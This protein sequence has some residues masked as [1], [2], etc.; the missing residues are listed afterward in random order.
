MTA[1]SEVIVKALAAS[2]P[3]TCFNWSA[4]RL[5]KGYR[6]KLMRFWGA[7]RSFFA[8]L[9][10]GRRPGQTLYT[11]ANSSW[12]MLYDFFIL[13][14]GR[15]LGYRL[16]LHHH[17]YSYIDRYDWRMGLVN[18]V[19]GKRGAHAVHC[20]KMAED[21]RAHYPTSA[22]FLMVP[23][24]I[25]SREPSGERNASVAGY[26][27]DRP[28]VLGFLSNLTLA[29]G[30]P[31][32]LETFEQLANDGADVQLLL[33]GPCLQTEA[34]ELVNSALDKWPQRIAY[35]GP[36][37]GAE[38]AAYYSAIDALLFPTEYRNESWGIVLSEALAAGH[39]VI[40]YDRGCVSYIV[41]GGCG[42]VV[43]Q[44]AD[45]VAEAVPLVRQWIQ[46]PETHFQASQ[47]ALRRSEELTAEA[48]RQFP[49]FVRQLRDLES[50]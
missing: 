31:L 9:V 47:Q 6:W 43:P 35:R 8:L 30:L 29:K 18:W 11:P 1:M 23:P 17:A 41:R 16:V 10:R 25:V 26:P 2:G 22:K 45:F 3:I 15:L 39:P 5:V 50:S 48:N 21:F 32:V 36:V 7:V 4:G 27:G 13:G 14:L 33:A 44:H 38:K 34:Q 42:T 28:F 46:A 19:V 12:G 37:Y 24:T 49:E 20:Q 40:A